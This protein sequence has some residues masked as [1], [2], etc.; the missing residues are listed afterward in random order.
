M[1][2]MR[3][4]L[5]A[6]LSLGLVIPAARARAGGYSAD[7]AQLG[8]VS[9]VAPSGAKWPVETQSPTFIF[10][11]PETSPQL[12]VTPELNQT[13]ISA[14]PAVDLSLTLDGEKG[15]S[16]SPSAGKESAEAAA[17]KGSSK[18]DKAKIRS[19]EDAIV[20]V[21]DGPTEPRPS[22]LSRISADN[23]WVRVAPKSVE[24][25][26]VRRAMK[27]YVDH[28]LA[29]TTL[30]AGLGSAVVGIKSVGV[31]AGLALNSVALGALAGLA[32]QAVIIVGVFLAASAAAAFSSGKSVKGRP[33]FYTAGLPS[34]GP[35][36]QWYTD[37]RLAVTALGGAIGA[38][39]GLLAGIAA[40]SNSLISA[41][42]LGA[43]AG[44]A[45]QGAAIVAALGAAAVLKAFRRA[46]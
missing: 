6:V 12:I 5:I 4:P 42:A 13:A 30:G 29:A 8:K 45:A 25:S 28:R 16:D 18:F 2:I 46:S 41:A 39:G 11:G 14:T 17:S 24:K 19:S 44:F 40:H 7:G 10:G 36:F 1:A 15:K 21:K 31:G 27:T 20:E 9:V 38:A 3:N 35:V 23:Q 43:G 32:A 33:F 22:N 34:G 37:H 26:L